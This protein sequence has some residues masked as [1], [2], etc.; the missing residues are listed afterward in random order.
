ML[1]YTAQRLVLSVVIV[2]VAVSILKL[3][4]H[5]V[6][7][8]PA[9]LVLGPRATPELI[10][11]TRE[12]MGLDRPLLMQL[13]TFFGNILRGD[14]GQDVFTGRAVSRIVFEQLPYTL[15]LIA[16][17]IMWSAV[18]GIVLGAYSALRRNTWFDTLSG[19]VSVGTISIPA[20]VMALYSVLIFAVWLRW[21]PAIG[22]G[23]GFLDSITHLILPAFAIGVSWVGYVARMV[24]ASMLEI[25]GQPHVRM[26]RAFGLP[27]RRITQSHIL[28]IAVLPAVTLIGTGVAHLFSAA[29]FVEVIFA[30]PGI[31]ALI[32]Q[33]VN[34]RNYPI[35]LGAVLVTTGIIVLATLISDLVIA[36]L[37]PRQ[38][39][40]L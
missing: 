27:E 5:V 40:E 2:M 13:V 17:A 25:M 14:L 30:R 4:L 23:E 12:A 7:G 24:R 34:E 26:A 29:V 20:F 18:L 8:D 3:M 19:V 35:V 6:P 9:V 16:V 31:G 36:L 37:D 22:A 21:L 10:E 33:A 38:R 28:K 32:V 39:E 15:I 1:F 11:R